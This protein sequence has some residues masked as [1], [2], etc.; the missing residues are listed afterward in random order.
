[1]HY[2]IALLILASCTE[3]VDL[4][5]PAQ[6]HIDQYTAELELCKNNV[7]SYS[8]KNPVVHLVSQAKVAPAA[9]TP[10]K[11]SSMSMNSYDMV[12]GNRDSQLV[13]IEYFSPT[14]PHCAYFHKTIFPELKRKYI[15]TNKIAYV[16]REFIGN[17]QDLD[18]AILARCKG[19]VNNFFKFTDA[20]LQ[21]QESWAA[22]SKY[23]DILTNIGQIGGI[24]PEKYSECLNNNELAEILINNTKAAARSPKFVGTPAFFIDGLQFN[25]AYSF[26]EISKSIDSNLELFISR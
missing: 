6:D 7:A 14:C 21:Q 19:D 25:G 23:R 20:L 9:L 1:M 4:T 16:V 26:E 15:D 24:T 18:A 11:F 12:L 17:K 3:K 13:V 5:T 2:L 8:Q 22:N 10:F